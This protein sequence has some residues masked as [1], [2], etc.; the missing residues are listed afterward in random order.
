MS[1]RSLLDSHPSPY[2]A[3]NPLE[4]MILDHLDEQ[5]IIGLDTLVALLPE[6]SWS[7]VFHAIDRLARRGRITLRRHRSEYTLFGTHYAA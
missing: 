5:G 2:V 7:Q 6:Y 1:P 4:D 3:V